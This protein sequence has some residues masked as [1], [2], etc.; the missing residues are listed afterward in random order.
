M[1][2]IGEGCLHDEIL[3][4]VTEHAMVIMRTHG[5]T[6]LDRVVMGSVA[7][8]VVGGCLSPY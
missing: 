5:R 4:C 7:E 8:R 3:E 1:T 6:G 2:E